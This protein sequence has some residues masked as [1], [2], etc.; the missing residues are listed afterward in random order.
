[1]L[2]RFRLTVLQDGAVM[3]DPGIAWIQFRGALQFTCGF[4]KLL[5]GY[6]VPCECAV[7]CFVIL[8][9]L[10]E[11]LQFMQGLFSSLWNSGHD[12]T[13]HCLRRGVEDWAHRH[14]DFI[15]TKGCG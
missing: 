1:M 15:L 12:V 7:G 14:A 9:I 11:L 8:R 4:V 10:G 3:P 6:V 13:D 2:S 5:L